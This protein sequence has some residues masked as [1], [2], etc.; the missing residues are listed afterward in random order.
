[1]SLDTINI[2]DIDKNPTSDPGETASLIA[3]ARNR[4]RLPLPDNVGDIWHIDIGFGPCRWVCFL[5]V[6]GS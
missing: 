4:S 1:M 3:A 5:Y 2:L 6:D